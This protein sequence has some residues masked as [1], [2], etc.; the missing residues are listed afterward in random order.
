MNILSSQARRFSLSLLAL[1]A[2]LF[3]GGCQN[4]Y[5]PNSENVSDELLQMRLL[6]RWARD[7]YEHGDNYAVF[8]DEFQFN[9]DGT[10]RYARIWPNQPEERRRTSVGTWSV[11]N[12]NLLQCWRKPGRP[13][14]RVTSSSLIE[15]RVREIVLQDE[16]GHIASYHRRPRP[17]DR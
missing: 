8:C 2:A 4:I 5:W 12:G 16:Y 10:F 14:S 13:V 11:S 6:G 1:C 17:E 7:G 15:T 3:L 9:D